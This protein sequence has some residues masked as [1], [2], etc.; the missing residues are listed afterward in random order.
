MSTADKLTSI[1]NSKTAIKN[2]IELKGVT[3]GEAPLANYAGLIGQIETGGSSSSSP[4]S[5][6]AT[7]LFLAFNNNFNAGGNSKYTVIKGEMSY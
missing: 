1:L 7:D 5:G 3:V 2:A 4:S 6:P